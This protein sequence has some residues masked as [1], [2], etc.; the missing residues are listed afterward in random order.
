MQ[1]GCMQVN[2]LCSVKH[3]RHTNLPLSRQVN[4]GETIA[5]C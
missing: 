2:G 5:L 3:C 4:V 1:V